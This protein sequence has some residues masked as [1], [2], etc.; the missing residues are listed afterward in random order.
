MAPRRLDYILTRRLFC[1]PGD[2]LQHRDVA[3]SDHEP[4]WVPLADSLPRAERPHD[5]P[6]WNSRCL[7]PPKY[8]DAVLNNQLNMSGDPVTM[9]QRVSQQITTARRKQIGFVESPEL[10]QLRHR[11]LVSPP[12]GEPQTPLEAESSTPQVGEESDRQGRSLVYDVRGSFEPL[13]FL[14]G[15]ATVSAR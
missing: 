11:A 1:N 2:V 6:S 5:P 12:G 8:V 14:R 7:R 9:L 4:V 10:K 13:G 15:G 3:T